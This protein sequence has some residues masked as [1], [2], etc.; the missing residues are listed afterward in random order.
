MPALTSIFDPAVAGAL[1]GPA[2][3]R[4]RRQEAAARIGDMELPTSDE[5]VWRYS[6][7][8]DLDLDRYGL[9]KDDEDE[10]ELPAAAVAAVDRIAARAGSVI[11]RN[12]RIVHA[13]LQPEWREQGVRLGSLAELDDVAEPLGS[14]TDRDGEPSSEYFETLNDAFT[15]EPVVLAVPAGVHVDRPVVVVDW[16]DAEGAATFPRL[17]VAL[18]ADAEATVLDHHGGADVEALVVPVVELDVGPAARLRYLNGQQRGA[19]T[20][21]IAA[22]LS[23]VGRDATLLAAQAAL[24]GGYARTRADCRLVGRGATGNL[25]AVYF[26]E[27]D[28]TLDF[29]TFQDHA[30]PDTTSNLLFKG[31]VG[32]HSRSVYTGLIRVRPEGRGTNAIQTNRTIKLSG[33]AWAESVPNL[34]I[35]NNDVRCAH[36]SAV[37]PIDEEQRFYLESR[38]VPPEVAERLLVTGFFDEV[39]EQLPVPE[40]VRD[41]QAAIAER[42]ERRQAEES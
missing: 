28:Q 41:L 31:A 42:L 12:G 11:V 17:V 13:E 39:F 18:G 6:P 34:E 20:W 21:Q 9:V 32:G 40:A 22:Q 14:V 10:P 37:G 29:R 19:R 26:G 4:A 38:G 27:G 36:A 16:N 8:D 33:H 15:A 7:I 23:R 25:T 24:G 2:W 3:L 35:E 1:P 5:E 30:A